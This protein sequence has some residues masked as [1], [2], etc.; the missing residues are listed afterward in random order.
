MDY[1]I[2]VVEPQ[3][4]ATI[5]GRDIQVVLQLPQA[6]SGDAFPQNVEDPKERQMNTPIFQVFVD[7]KS[8]GNLP[9]GQNVFVAHDVPFGAHK[10]VVMAKNV[11]G[12]V[13]D[14]AEIPVTSVESSG[15]AASTQ[16]TGSS[17][18]GMTSAQPAGSTYGNETD[19]RTGSAAR[20]GAE[21]TA[22]TPSRPARL[23]QTASGAPE[24][25]AA[26]LLLLTAGLLSRRG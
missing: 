16:T 9:G 26:G 19:R 17:T 20:A 22:S 15:G 8:Y 25:A 7:G 12:E 13:I 11:A 4:N 10:I 5:V 6:P 14:R 18:A 24:L 2:R 21:A 23:P 3:P 1:R